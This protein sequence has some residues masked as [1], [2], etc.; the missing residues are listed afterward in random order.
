MNEAKH[1]K[2]KSQIE[3]LELMQENMLNIGF[4]DNYLTVSGDE[5]FKDKC[6]NL[7]A[8]CNSEVTNKSLCYDL[9]DDELGQYK[10]CVSESGARTIKVMMTVARG[11]SIV[12]DKW[13]SHS[14]K[15]KRWANPQNYEKEFG[16]WKNAAEKYRDSVIKKRKRTKKKDKDGD[17]D[18]NSSDSEK[19]I[20]TSGPLLSDYSIYVQ[21]RPSKIKPSSLS[22]K[23]LAWNAGA[24]IV[25]QNWKN[26]RLKKK[27]VN[28]G[29]DDE[30]DESDS[31]QNRN[32]KN[33]NKKSSK[34][35]S[36]KSSKKTSKRKKK[37]DDSDDDDDDD[38]DDDSD[39]D[40]DNDSGNDKEEAGDEDSDIEENK[41]KNK[42]KKR[43]KKTKDSGKKKKKI[44]ASRS[45]GED[46]GK[47]KR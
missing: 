14:I 7:I 20:A 1:K 12:N 33:S 26:E 43:R 22:L 39:N 45:I 42:N 44:K 19:E 35:S 31:D 17:N 28:D 11:G 36:R 21:D 15:G 3:K 24:Q 9:V 47:K 4:R 5:N 32:N 10:V 27:E 41:N 37:K 16:N 40:S 30:K 8:V 46:S 23:H 25:N 13:I 6:R 29:L 18:M 2:Q 34:K 38:D